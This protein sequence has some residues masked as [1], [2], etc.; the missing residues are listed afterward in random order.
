MEEFI[1]DII[2]REL[3]KITSMEDFK[4]FVAIKNKNKVLYLTENDKIEQVIQKLI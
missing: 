4:R 1:K 2:K 3:H